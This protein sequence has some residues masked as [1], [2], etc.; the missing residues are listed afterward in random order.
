MNH[1]RDSSASW[2]W[3]NRQALDHDSYVAYYLEN[4]ETAETPDEIA[5]N[6]SE[7][8]AEL[9]SALLSRYARG[10]TMDALR[11]YFVDVY[12]PNLN[13][14]RRLQSASQVR[15]R[16]TIK[17]EG[18]ASWMLLFALICFDEDGSRITHLDDWFAPFDETPLV[19][20]VLKG[21]VPGR[22]Y[23][24]R[25]DARRET[26]AHEQP[27]LTALLQPQHAWPAAF[28]DFMQQWPRLMVSHD[29]RD[30]VDDNKPP[31]NEFPFHVGVAV[32]AF[33]I[34]DTSFRDLPW[35]PRDLVDYYR[36]HRRN[37]RD[38]WRADLIDPTLGLPDSAR[39]Q[40]KKTS[41]LSMAR[42]YTRWV[43]L[44]SGS[45][46]QTAYARKALGKRKTMAELFE[47]M[48]ALASEG[49]AIQADI[50]DDET[51]EAQ[52]LTLCATRKLPPPALPAQPPQGPARI[53][54]LLHALQTHSA[55]HGQQMA[56]LGDDLWNVVLHDACSD[57]EFAALCEQLRVTQMAESDWR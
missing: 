44:V 24:E 41:V 48:Q 17:F 43:E 27:V 9:A 35:Y 3:H 40:P 31:F 19:S 1:P 49:L 39:P 51:V 53:I 52:L 32:C 11:A 12:L 4:A 20:M 34:D 5:E 37:V 28:T 25:Y 54:A 13:Q 56:V 26:I 33:D 8:S 6:L 47:V 30:Q 55:Q 10:D 36:R 29:Y 46:E 42:A 15:P 50:K 18:A 23:S 16:R 57:Q 38:A 45:A 21:F 14:A 2:A 22:C 7:L